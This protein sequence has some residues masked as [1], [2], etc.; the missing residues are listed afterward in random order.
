MRRG[1][2]AVFIVSK[3]KSLFEAPSTVPQRGLESTYLALVAARGR[4]VE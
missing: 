3:M 4:G 2:A 1:F